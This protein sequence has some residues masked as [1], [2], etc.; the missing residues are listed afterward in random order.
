MWTNNTDSGNTA[1]MTTESYENM[2]ISSI[3][4]CVCLCVQVADRQIVWYYM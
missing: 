4:V 1:Q 3:G 2:C